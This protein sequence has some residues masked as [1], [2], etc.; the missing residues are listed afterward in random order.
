MNW[1]DVGLRDSKFETV[2]VELE[3]R[4]QSPRTSAMTLLFGIVPEE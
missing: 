2:K 4:F 3:Y 1:Q